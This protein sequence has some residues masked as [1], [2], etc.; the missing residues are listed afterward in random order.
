MRLAVSKSP[1]LKGSSTPAY[2]GAWRGHHDGIGADTIW[3]P[4]LSPMRVLP[5]NPPWAYL[6][7][8]HKLLRPVSAM[9]F[10]ATGPPGRQY[11]I[12][13][14]WATLACWFRTTSLVYPFGISPTGAVVKLASINLQKLVLSPTGSINLGFILREDLLL[15]SSYLPLG[16]PNWAVIYTPSWTWIVSYEVLGDSDSLSETN[17]CRMENHRGKTTKAS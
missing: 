9:G 1:C 13:P 16:V 5:G 3:S 14:Q 17:T 10:P 12:P 8:R 6:R 15:C 11:A 4:R 2:K 7:I